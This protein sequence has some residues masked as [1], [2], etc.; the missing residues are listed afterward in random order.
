MK[1]ES[2]EITKQREA[3]FS[4]WERE[5]VRM[6]KKNDPEAG[7]V[8]D[9]KRPPFKANRMPDFSSIRIYGEEMRQ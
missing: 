3:P 2:I 7:L 1:Q 4:F 6:A 9:C 5:K 8:N